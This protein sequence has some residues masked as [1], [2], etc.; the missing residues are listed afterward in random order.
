VQTARCSPSTGHRA[1][2]SMGC[3]LRPVRRT[4]LRRRPTITQP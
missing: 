4:L 3:R 2:H 1:P